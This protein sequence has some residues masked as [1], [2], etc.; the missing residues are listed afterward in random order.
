[1][2]LAHIFIELNFETFITWLLFGFFD[3]AFD[4]MFLSLLAFQS[5]VVLKKF[6][7]DSQDL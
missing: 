6:F 2:S 5:I 4:I 7:E 3:R 1:M